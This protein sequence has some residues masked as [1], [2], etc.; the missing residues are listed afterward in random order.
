[1]NR[2]EFV[3]KC[4]S[5]GIASIEQ[6]SLSA[7]GTRVRQN[8]NEESTISI[9][10]GRQL[11]VDDFLIEESNLSRSF[12]PARLHEQNPVLKPQTPV[13]SNNGICPVACP[14]G[15]GVF[16]DPRD[17]LFKMWYHAGWFDG[18]AYAISEDGLQWRRP[19]LD[20]QPG[21]NRVLPV[22]SGYR[23]DGATVWLDNEAADPM[24][25]FKMFIYLRTKDSEGGHIY[26]S[27]DGIHWVEAGKT[28]PCG[29]NTCFYYDPFRKSWIYSIR[30][31]DQSIRIRSYR[32]D[33]DFIRGANWQREDLIDWLRADDL[34]LPDPALGYRPQLYKFSAAAYESLMLGVFA[35]FKGPPNEVAAQ[36]GIPKT[37]DLCL[38]FSRDGFHWSRMN[39]SPFLACSRVS[40]TWNRGYLHSAGGICLI[41][42]DELYFY[43]GG[44]SGISPKLGGNLYAGASTGLA[45]LRRDGFASLDAD[46]QPGCVT[47]RV[48]TFKGKYLFVNLDTKLGELR[49]ELLD[50]QGHVIEPFSARNCIPVC[51]DKTRQLVSW[52]L[53]KDLSVVAGK[54]LRIRFYVTSGRL[55][56]FWV[57]PNINGSSYGYVAGGGPGFSTFKDI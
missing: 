11:F 21:T 56:A 40:G 24:Q 39:H 41:V 19:S 43:F 4:A 37:I 51:A 2:R 9:D 6:H 30:S 50:H 54:R 53:G 26:T 52:K 49:V 31:Y 28:G 20:V 35:I 13:E 29:D 27:P 3:K 36:M 22:R 34:D 45:V 23:R 8:A 55:Y 5:A 1:M 46:R 18:T 16:Y 10:V 7:A 17:R 38:G 57:S 42:G 12:H 33:R 44:F 47:T 15:D 14:F 32:A 25:R 48:I